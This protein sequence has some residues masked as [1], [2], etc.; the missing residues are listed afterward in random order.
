VK[1][2][3][4]ATENQEDEPPEEFEPG[5]KGVA[6]FLTTQN[7]TPPQL[8]P[9]APQQNKTEQSKTDGG[10]TDPTKSDKKEENKTKED[11]W[12]EDLNKFV[13]FGVEVDE[14]AREKCPHVLVV[15]AAGSGKSA[16]L[17]NWVQNHATQ[18]EDVVTIPYYIGCAPSTRG[19]R[20]IF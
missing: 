5:Q 16:L 3:E 6:A 17:C 8:T 10:T 12:K 20:I 15:G 1:E 2:E 18:F 7:N 14:S 4:K 19:S 11:K 13:H 9:G